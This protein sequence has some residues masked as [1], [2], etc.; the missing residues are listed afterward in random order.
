MNSGKKL[1]QIVN[2]LYEFE[3]LSQD[4]KILKDEKM[5]FQGGYRQIDVLIKSNVARV[6]LSIAIECKD[7][8]RPTS[9][10][11]IE[12][13][14]NKISSLKINKGIFIATAG[15]QS[16]AKEAAKYY[17]VEL[18]RIEEQEKI[19]L[20]ASNVKPTMAFGLKV[21]NI[22]LKYRILISDGQAP[23][24]LFKITMGLGL[25]GII[26]KCLKEEWFPAM[27]E[28]LCVEQAT[29]MRI[30]IGLIFPDMETHAGSK[31]A[32]VKVEF[33]LGVDLRF[34]YPHYHP[35]TYKRIDDRTG[36]QLEFIPSTS[37]DDF[38][39]SFESINQE[40][41]TEAYQGKDIDPF[42]Y[43]SRGGQF[44]MPDRCEFYLSNENVLRYD[45]IMRDDEKSTTSIDMFRFGEEETD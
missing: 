14:A 10:S 5:P 12:A 7:H 37:V 16:G 23:G 15:F 25:W 18:Y 32:D 31:L 36:E 26:D 8:K 27:K 42:V 38:L 40:E 24:L 43:F 3:N 21:T 19:V 39:N 13:F 30:V 34:G 22:N 45:F 2:D 11:D 44:D 35:Q 17:G 20:S 41:H 1:E 33:D 9:I 29:S 4:Y 28:A 6:D